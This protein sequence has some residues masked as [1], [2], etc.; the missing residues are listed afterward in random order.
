MTFT[1]TADVD[2]TS[3]PDPGTQAA[4]VVSPAEALHGRYHETVTSAAR[5]KAEY[6]FAVRTDCLR[7]GDRCMSYFH[8]PDVAVPLVFGGGK[9]TQNVDYGPCPAGGTAHVKITAQYPLPA[10][11]QDPITLLTGHAHQEATGSACVSFDADG[12]FVRTGD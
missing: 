7:T 9:W 2:V 1:R 4:R 5:G 8:N 11:P 12:E 6:D 3:L 10:P